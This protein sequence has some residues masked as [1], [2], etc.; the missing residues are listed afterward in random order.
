M[1]IRCLYLGKCPIKEGNQI[2]FKV[3]HIRLI[4]DRLRKLVCLSKVL[5]YGVVLPYKTCEKRLYIKLNESNNYPP[6]LNEGKL[7]VYL[8]SFELRV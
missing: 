3:V 8:L 6:K 1:M 7:I 4:L 5:K 2:A